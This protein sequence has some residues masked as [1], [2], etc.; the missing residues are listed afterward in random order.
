MADSNNSGQFDNREGTE[1][2][3]HKGGEASTGSFGQEKG[4]DPH[5]AGEE[6][7]KAQSIEAKRQGG[8]E[9]SRRAKR[10]LAVVHCLNQCPQSKSRNVDS[11]F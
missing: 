9:Y 5:K 3:A 11:C 8:R 1:E 4:A 10:Q 7:G 6:G 2:Q